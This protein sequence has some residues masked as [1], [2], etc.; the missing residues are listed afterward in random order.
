MYSCCCATLTIPMY[1]INGILI[2]SI[3]LICLVLIGCTKEQAESNRTYEAIGVVNAISASK[4][5]INID[6]E[7]IEGFMDAM[8]MFFSAAGFRAG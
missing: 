5:H 1:S 6:H 7:E 3:A 2:S 8:Q 4:A